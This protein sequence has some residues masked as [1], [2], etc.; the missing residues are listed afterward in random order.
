MAD[1]MIAGT[2]TFQEPKTE[3]AIMKLAIKKE[4]VPSSVLFFHS[5]TLPNFIPKMAAAGSARERISKE[6]IVTFLSKRR[7]VKNDPKR[8]MENVVIELFSLSLIAGPNTLSTN[9]LTGLS[10]SLRRSTASDT[11]V[12]MV[13]EIT[14]VCSLPSGVRE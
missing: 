7:T 13:R 8:N 3:N 5:L 12:R 14:K 9:F 6:A 2:T 4:A 1:E 10:F 11:R